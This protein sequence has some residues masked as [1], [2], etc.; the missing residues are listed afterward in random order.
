[1]KKKGVFK[2]ICD[3]LRIYI[4]RVVSRGEREGGEGDNG[5]NLHH[6]TNDLPDPAGFVNWAY[7]GKAASNRNTGRIEGE[8]TWATVT[9]D[10][11]F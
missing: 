2:N 9:S 8:D 5:L 4:F 6:S 7:G 11:R 10:C 3:F 1:L